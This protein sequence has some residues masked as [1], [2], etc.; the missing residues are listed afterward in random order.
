MRRVWAAFILLGIL[1]GLISS[2][3][4]AEKPLGSQMTIDASGYNELGTAVAYSSLHDQYLVVYARE[5]DTNHSDIY[6]RFVD[7]KTQTA[8]GDPFVIANEADGGI[9]AD[10]KYPDVA[11]DPYKDRFVVVYSHSTAGTSSNSI[12][13]ARVVYGSYQISGSQI[14]SGANY[15]SIQTISRKYSTPA[16]AY[17]ADEH[18]FM[19]VY[20]EDLDTITGAIFFVNPAGNSLTSDPG[21]GPF[22]IWQDGEILYHHDVAWG[23]SSNSN[24]LVVWQKYDGSAGDRKIYGRYMYDT[25]QGSS[26]QGVNSSVYEISAVTTRGNDRHYFPA[27]AF[28]L[29]DD[30]YGVVYMSD[31][32]ASGGPHYQIDGV[33][34]GGSPG[35]GSPIVSGSRTVIQPLDEIPGDSHTYPD[36]SYSGLDGIFQV[37]YVSDHS[38][39]DEDYS[40]IFMRWYTYSGASGA[41]SGR[42]LVSPGEADKPRFDTSIDGAGNG[43]CLVAWEQEFLISDHDI[44]A[45]L[46]APYEVFTPVVFK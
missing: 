4:Q 27:A 5:I 6:G 39:F 1:T 23:G 21:A 46:M 32:V 7:P 10:E 19:T 20:A 38:F 17:N 36:I 44:Y 14:P 2:N 8:I 11:Y 16:I 18:Q 31:N 12:I 43:H 35:T 30:R 42:T 37:S 3:A 13:K 28:N 45:R 24:F 40:D 26:D 29:R 25:D 33:M 9:N 41:A 22:D 15:A 34:L